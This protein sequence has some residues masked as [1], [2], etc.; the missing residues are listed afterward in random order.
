LR[1]P[2]FGAGD[3]AGYPHK[4]PKLPVGDRMPVDPEPVDGNVIGRRFFRVALGYDKVA[5]CDK[6]SATTMGSRL[7]P[8]SLRLGCAW[9]AL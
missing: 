5:F 7:R 1:A 8:R 9:P 6:P 2:K 3:A 4:L